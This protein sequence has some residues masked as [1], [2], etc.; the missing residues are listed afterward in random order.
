[1][2]QKERKG[3][4]KK[5]GKGEKGEKK[6]EVFIQPLNINKSDY[7]SKILFHVSFIQEKTQI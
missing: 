5:R 4:K 2:A 1:M 6:E 7:I 3:K